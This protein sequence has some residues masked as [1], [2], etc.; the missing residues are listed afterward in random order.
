MAR[1]R[2]YCVGARY[3]RFF[4]PA[5]IFV[6]A[7]LS[8]LGT[9]QLGPSF[10]N[11]RPE[12][13]HTTNDR[14]IS[15]RPKRPDG[16]QRVISKDV[17]GW[18]LNPQLG[19]TSPHTAACV[20]WS[21][22][23]G[24]MNYLAWN[25]GTSK[26]WVER[27]TGL[28]GLVDC[29][30]QTPDDTKNLIIGAHG[31]PDLVGPMD[32]SNYRWVADAVREKGITHVAF[33]SCS[34]GG[35]AGS[36]QYGSLPKR[37]AKASG[38]DVTAYSNTV[39]SGSNQFSAQY[40]TTAYTWTSGESGR[41]ADHVGVE[42]GD[43][44]PNPFGVPYP[45]GGGRNQ[46]IAGKGSSGGGG[47]SGSSPEGGGGGGSPNYQSK[48]S[49]APRA[50]QMP[51]PKPMQGLDTMW[52]N[53]NPAASKPDDGLKGFFEAMAQRDIDD[54]ARFSL[55]EN[56]M[57]TVNQDLSRI[58]S[59]RNQLIIDGMKALTELA[60]KPLISEAQNKIQSMGAAL[61][62]FGARNGFRQAPY[63]SLTSRSQRS[64]ASLLGRP[65]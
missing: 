51:T 16:E 36:I 38:A 49:P 22:G 20:N 65:R 23:N 60:I 27:Y 19:L 11:P 62:A 31:A 50:A 61:S 63:P 40:P 34:A 53:L 37:F 3:R 25:A 41:N 9:P 44:S 5:A 57:R 55:W 4:Y 10:S 32:L 6:L 52:D 14:K 8:A 15:P 12:R 43:G 42:E 45:Y 7:C 18:N 47:S 2:A 59:E 33:A 21:C 39:F 13:R 30:K 64:P 46:A 28:S 58:I 1:A 29:V 56:A 54:K 35:N 26:A 24:A 17:T 48:R